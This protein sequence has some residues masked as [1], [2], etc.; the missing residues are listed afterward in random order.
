MRS[1][2]A[3]ASG[4]IASTVTSPPMATRNGDQLA[5]RGRVRNGT[6]VATA[7]ETANGR[8][9]SPA[10]PLASNQPTSMSNATPRATAGSD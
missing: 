4:T 8:S 9:V 5:S 3:I 10:R 7:S 2:S 6:A 1:M